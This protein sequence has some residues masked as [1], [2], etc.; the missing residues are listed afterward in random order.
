MVNGTLKTSWAWYVWIENEFCTPTSLYAWIET[1]HT[2]IHFIYPTVIHG[3]CDKVSAGQIN[4]RIL[5]SMH[6]GYGWTYT[7]YG[8]NTHVAVAELYDG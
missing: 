4:I 6:G 2:H 7:G 3:L 1:K 8:A 5:L